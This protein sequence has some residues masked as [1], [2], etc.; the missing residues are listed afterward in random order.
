MGGDAMAATAV[1]TANERLTGTWFG[2]PKGLFVLFFTE[3]WERFSY[4]GM[5][6]L[7]VLYM[8]NYLFIRPDVGARVLGFNAVRGLYE[9]L[10]HASFAAQPLSSWVY[11]LYTGFVYFTPF[12]GGLLADRILGQRRTVVVGGTLMAIGHF[13]MASERL[14]FPALFCLI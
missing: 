11:G 3:M 8:V 12:F 9:S 10:F 5:R 14:F 13:M 1:A 2:H 7:L 6:S 4:Y